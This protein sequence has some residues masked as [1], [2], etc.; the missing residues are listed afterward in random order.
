MQSLL[1]RLGTVDWLRIAVVFSKKLINSP[2]RCVI[3]QHKGVILGILEMKVVRTELRWKV[4]SYFR[5]DYWQFVL[6]VLSDGAVS[7]KL[8]LWIY[9]MS[10][11]VAPV[12]SPDG[13]KLLH[14]LCG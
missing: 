5:L 7:G 8:D 3:T 14:I 12:V 10:D 2:Y 13:D 6:S 9:D 11:N 4:K 1:A